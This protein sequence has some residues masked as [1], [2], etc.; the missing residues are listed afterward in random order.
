MVKNDAGINNITYK[1][2][3]VKQLLIERLERVKPNMWKNC[4]SQTKAEDNLWK[5]DFIVADDVLSAVE[6][7]VTMTI[8]DT[9]SDDSSI[10]PDYFFILLF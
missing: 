5:I 1:L 10:T 3:D 4:I 6:E 8:G 2:T 7:S 9:S